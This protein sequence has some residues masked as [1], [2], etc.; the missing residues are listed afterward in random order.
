MKTTTD[1]LEFLLSKL[2]PSEIDLLKTTASLF[3]MDSD[4][5]KEMMMQITMG[6]NEYGITS[7]LSAHYISGKG[8][9]DN[10]FSVI[11]PKGLEMWQNYLVRHTKQFIIDRKPELLQWAV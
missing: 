4:E 9:G 2:T 10:V 11:T 3:G 5:R 8:I 1:H 7:S 6:Y